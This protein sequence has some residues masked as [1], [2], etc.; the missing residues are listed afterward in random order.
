MSYRIIENLEP[1]LIRAIYKITAKF[2]IQ[3]VTAKKIATECDV[4]DFT[5]IRCFGT[6]NAALEAAALAFDRP[7]LSK[8]N[9]LASQNVNLYEVWDQMMEFLI[10][11]PDG[12]FFYYEY[13]SFLVRDPTE[14]HVRA[15]EFL[16]TIKSI[17]PSDSLSDHGFLV[18]WDYV[19]SMTLYY[20]VKFIRNDLAYNEEN[21]D[22]VRQIVGGGVEKLVGIKL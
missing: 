13:K 3:N 21:R 14:A 22:I 9:E 17:I 12:T 8:L 1:R 10:S 16:Q 18:L 5:A 2:G 11:D 6:M 19:T 15:G 7:F 4:S 20:A